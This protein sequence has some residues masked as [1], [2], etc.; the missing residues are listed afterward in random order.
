M[1]DISN[2]KRGMIIGARLARASFPRTINLM[3]ISRITVSRVIL[4]D[5]NP[6]KIS[7]AKHTIELISKLKDCG[8]TRKLERGARPWMEKKEKA[9]PW[10]EKTS[11]ESRGW[12]GLEES[13]KEKG[14]VR[15]WSG[16]EGKTMNAPVALKNRRDWMHRLGI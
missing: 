13:A 8:E 3:V 16:K 2:A 15:D 11:E 5:T 14:L 10:M 4:A 6:G 1:F 9:L 7:S 12:N